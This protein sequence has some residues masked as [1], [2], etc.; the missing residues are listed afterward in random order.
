MAKICKSKVRGSMSALEDGFRVELARLG[1]APTST[2][3][4]VWLMSRLSQWL[5]EEGVEVAALNESVIDQ[6]VAAFRATGQI[7]GRSLRSFA[8]MLTWLRRDGVARPEALSVP[9]GLDVMIERYHFWMDLDRGLATRTMARYETTARR[10]LKWRSPAS[11]ETF[12]AGLTG[13][14]VTG[15]LLHERNR[16]LAAGSL[17]GR[18]AEL[19]SLLRFLH[20]AGFI[21]SSLAGAVPP[22]AGWRDT[23]LPATMPA[24]DVT[25]LLAGCDRTTRAG[26]RDLAV[27]MLLARMGLRAA[28]VAGLQLDH[29]DW[30]AG[31]LVVHGKGGRIERLPLPVDV[32]ETLVD[33]LTHA[34]PPVHASRALILSVQAPFRT[35][36]STG[37]GQLVWRA[38]VRAGVPPVRSHRLRHTLATTM[39]REGVTLQDIG[40][41]LRHRDL[42]T[43][44]TYAKV[45]STALRYLARPWPGARQ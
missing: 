41:V 40:Q 10:F 21:P 27:L 8:P 19:R 6:F 23:A 25:A 22:V 7:R 29:V 9:S 33:Y 43:T 2:E 11:P 36:R 39:L 32:G 3:Y 42:A 28:E 44:A 17:K 24:A 30:R 35:L 45:D 12:V 26:R 37:I 1:Y 31:E 38:C 13:A 16:R 20:L 5:D 18:V 4:Q 15:F 34:R 14:E